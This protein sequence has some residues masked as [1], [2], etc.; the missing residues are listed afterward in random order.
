MSNW[1]RK[2][3]KNIYSKVEQEKTRRKR[4]GSIRKNSAGIAMTVIEYK[5][6]DNMTVKFENGY[7]KENVHWSSFEKGSVKSPYDRSVY[8]VGYLGEGKIDH[9]IYQKWLIMLGK[10]YNPELLKKYKSYQGNKVCNMWLNFQVFEKWYKKNHYTVDNELM[11]LNK[12]IIVPNSKIY[13]PKTCIF[14]PKTINNLFVTHY[15]RKR[16]K[17]PNNICK[18]NNKYVIRYTD[19]NNNRKTLGIVK[20]LDEAIVLLE[21]KKKELIEE[22][23]QKY[24]D[25]IPARL[26]NA[27]VDYSQ[28]IKKIKTCNSKYSKEELLNLLK[29]KNK[30]LGRTPTSRDIEV[31]YRDA[32]RRRF[33]TW[34]NALIEAGLKTNRNFYTNDELSDML[35]RLAIKLNKTPSVEDVLTEYNNIIDTLKERFGSYNNAIKLAKLQV[36][37]SQTIIKETN[38]ELLQIYKNFCNK[39]GKVA[40]AKDLNN[41]KEVYNSGVFIIR[42]GSMQ[43]LQQLAGLTPNFNA[44][45]SRYNKVLIT[46][47]L[48][49][50]YKKY[51]RKLTTKEIKHNKELPDL[52]TILKYFKTTKI[53]VVWLEIMRNREDE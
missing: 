5:N 43:E 9:L 18:L 38:E 45:K 19:L 49:K 10:C 15:N 3:I 27:L 29:S 26:Y 4:L 17:S 11:F 39:I 51:G 53:S 34:N 14:V 40:S 7:I 44:N 28:K 33:K 32:L 24:K 42:F 31:K 25:K 13:S 41:D 30:E 2:Y 48:I 22:V 47:M 35:K 46:E 23:A 20:N 6:C 1:N 21:N 12:N 36:N 37:I 50:A 8:G 16:I 52:N